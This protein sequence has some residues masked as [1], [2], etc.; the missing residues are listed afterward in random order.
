M[1]LDDEESLDTVLAMRRAQ[2]DTSFCHCEA[3]TV[4]KQSQ[5]GRGLPRTF[6]VLAMTKVIPGPERLDWA[7]FLNSG[8][9]YG[10]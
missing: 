6:Q 9:S 1:K 8:G 5:W 4:P 3:R 10:Q 2:N 7:N